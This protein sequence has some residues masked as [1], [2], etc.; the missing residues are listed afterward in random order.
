MKR[1]QDR[2]PQARTDELAV[3]DLF[4]ETLVY[5]LKRHS[6]HCLNRAAVVIWRQCDGRTT[7]A[8]AAGVLH[9]RLGVP[10]NKDLIWTGLLRLKRAHLLADQVDAPARGTGSSRREALR[11]LGLLGVLPAVLSIVA[12]RAAEAQSSVTKFECE[13]L[14][15]GFGLPCSDDPPNICVDKGSSCDCD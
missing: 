3:E 6:V 13:V 10:A 15:M 2:M 8:E 14:C 1:T 7:V 5:D 11:A 4:D 9:A 12:P